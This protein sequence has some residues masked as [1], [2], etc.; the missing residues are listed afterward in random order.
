M[1]AY[2]PIGPSNVDQTIVRGVAFM[3]LCSIALFLAY[4]LDFILVYLLF[5]FFMRGFLSRKMSAF[6]WLS[7]RLTRA[8]ACKIEP[9]NA[10]PKVFAARIGFITC[11]LILLCKGLNL[12]L[13]AYCLSAALMLAAALESVFSVCLG[14]Y[15]YNLINHEHTPSAAAGKAHLDE[16]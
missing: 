14:C 15:I 1:A 7:Q 11:L 12:A 9:V 3:T 4:N 8:F 5:D 13:L 10:E 16:C 6:V 2:C